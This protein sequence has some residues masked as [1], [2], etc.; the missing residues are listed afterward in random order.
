MRFESSADVI[1]IT[2]PDYQTRTL[3]RYG[4]TD[5]RLELYAPQDG[6]FMQENVTDSTLIASATTG[7]EI[8]LNS[9]T[10]L[11]ATTHVGSFW[12]LRHYVEGQTDSQNYASTGNGTGITCFTT[13]RLITH[14]TWTGTLKVE[15]S[16]DA[17]V[18]W[19]NLRTF[20][21][22]DDF[23]PN[24]S[25]TEDVDTNT[26]PFLVRTNM[27][28]H[29]SGNCYADITADSFYQEGIFEFL[30]YNTAYA[31]TG[32]VVET[33]ADTT[34][35]KSWREGSWS[36][37]RGWPKVAR[38]Y[39]DRLCFAATESEPMNIWMT[40]TGNY[41]SYKV[42][43]ILLDSDAITTS[44]PSRQLNAINGLVAMNKL[45]ALTSSSEWT[46]GSTGSSVL[47]P[48]SIEQ[49]IEGYRGS[50]GVN[51]V[52]VGNEA[53]YVQ[54]AGKVVRNLGYD[55]GSDSFTGEELNILSKHLV[56]RWSILDMAY[57]QDPDSIVWL[58][59]DDGK[60]LAMTYMREQKV[61]AWT[62][63]DTGSDE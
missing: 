6:P 23:N 28:V 56:D 62:I 14:G 50:A 34:A 11:F 63:N 18:T 38:F 49:K 43:S 21:G 25:G 7:N 2:H 54:N 10:A 17:G 15:K 42:N 32:K 40:Q 37:Y 26:V 3:S 8:S 60:L 41:I 46:I 4:E 35:T 45:I 61:V 57:Q 44:L 31:C 33:I 5:W 24:T 52:V 20:T 53:I 30:T 16:V 13:W 9:A 27:T 29:S 47:T 55:F 1:Y 36:D 59:R 48:T 22:A 19:T 58:L 51:P 39:Q 12:K